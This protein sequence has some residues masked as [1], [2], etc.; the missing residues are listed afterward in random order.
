[1]SKKIFITL[2]IILLILLLVWY[3]LPKQP[4]ES[5]IVLPEAT[6]NVDDLEN[7]LLMELADIESMLL[8]ED[9][10]ADLIISDNVEIDNFGQSV[11]ENEL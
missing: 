11:D 7:A 4:E 1:M 2:I 5:E 10:D 8:E 9:L 6:G 3:F